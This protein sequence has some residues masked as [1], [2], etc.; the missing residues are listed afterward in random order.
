MRMICA[1]PAASEPAGASAFSA[2]VDG[3]GMSVPSLNSTGAL[4]GAAASA[5]AATATRQSLVSTSVTAPGRLAALGYTARATAAAVSV[6][7]S[8]G[9]RVV[10]F[11]ALSGKPR[12]SGS[13]RCGATSAGRSGS[14][15]GVSRPQPTAATHAT[16]STAT[17]LGLGI[18]RHISQMP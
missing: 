12:L 10:F 2:D 4:N 14:V 5:D 7:S 16:S 8:P 9:I 1:S 18:A 15:A 13:A 11:V 17:S 6:A 3:P